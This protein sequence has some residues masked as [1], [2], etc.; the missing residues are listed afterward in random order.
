MT[1]AE[2]VYAQY[3]SS[4]GAK[5]SVMLPTTTQCTKSGYV[6]AGFSTSSTA[7]TPTY[8]PGIAYTPTADIVLYAVWE[9]IEVHTSDY[10]GKPAGFT[11]INTSSTNKKYKV[12]VRVGS[13]WQTAIPYVYYNGTWVIAG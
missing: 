1:A 13:A 7:T 12:Y 2:T 3:S 4:T 8:V 5:T 6:L 11:V 10:I 9:I